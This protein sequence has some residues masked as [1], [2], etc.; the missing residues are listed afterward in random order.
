MSQRVLLPN[1]QP[2][3]VLGPLIDVDG[4]SSKDEDLRPWIENMKSWMRQR[5]AAT[6]VMVARSVS[7]DDSQTGYVSSL[8]LRSSARDEP[9]SAIEAQDSPWMSRSV[10]Q[11]PPSPPQTIKR[12]PPSADAASSSS[13]LRQGNLPPNPPSNL[14]HARNPSQS[15]A[16]T[17][18]LSAVSSSSAHSRQTSSALA[19]P[20]LLPNHTRG[21]SYNAT[22]RLSQQLT[23]KKSLPDL[24]QS[25]AK[26][27]QERR[28]HGKVDDS[29]T[30][31]LGITSPPLHKFNVSM[32]RSVSRDG[33]LYSPTIARLM[34]TTMTRK[35]SIDALRRPVVDQTERRNSQDLPSADD[36]RNS[37]FRR[38]STLPTSTISKTIPPAL[39][40]F[41]DAIRGVLFALSQLHSALRHYLAFA[42]SERA[43]GMFARVMEPAGAYINNLINTLD[44][45]DSMSRRATPPASAIRG[46]LR[47]TKDSVVVFSKMMA[48]LKLQLPAIRGTDT[49]YARTLLTMIYGSMSEVAASWKAMNP[50]LGRIQPL[51]RAEQP[52]AVRAIMAAGHT[53]TRSGSFGV[54]TPISP[55]PERG[56]SHSPPSVPRAQAAGAGASPLRDDDAIDDSPAPLPKIV[57]ADKNRFRRQGGSFSTQ[58]FERGMLMASPVATKSSHG[59]AHRPSASEQLSTTAMTDIEEQEVI[60]PLKESPP[61]ADD[62]HG[63]PIT[64][65]DISSPTV[66]PIVMTQS[67]QHGPSSSSG[68]ANGFVFGSHAHVAP[69]PRLTT[70]G[71]PSTP[72]PA[73][74][75]DKDLLE[76]VEA[77]TEIA[78]DVWLKLAEDVGITQSRPSHS[79]HPSTSS[80]G[81]T[82]SARPSALQPKHQA[83]LAHE[84]RAAESITS[85]LRETL[86]SL[87]ANQNYADTTLSED[88]ATFIKAVIRVSELVKA[89]TRSHTFDPIVRA[90]LSRLTQVTREC[91]ILMQ[92]SSLGRA[93]LSDEVKNG[94][95]PARSGKQASDDLGA[96]LSASLRGLQLPSRQHAL[97]RGRV[98]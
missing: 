19:I 64:P 26:I 38:L 2:R 66:Q 76:V 94:A 98:E 43:A 57:S 23:V 42:V 4:K 85:K 78:F 7:D 62:T 73:T 31:G 79:N 90:A 87:R 45:F 37:Y 53:M 12:V 13:P 3:E 21:S 5:D 74:V 17:P 67:S 97:R 20:P 52:A 59:S 18:P 51:L 9:G 96:P 68:S 24:R 22:Q 88:A 81:S 50:L 65:P 80:A 40:E 39:L 16:S 14:K 75:Y 34:S 27:I 33:S 91:A 49:R 63:V 61:S 71:R 55:I 32:T 15:S 92:V 35:G 89:I 10:S 86:L 25:H 84:L 83:E 44:R 29:R 56:E 47:A 6:Q 70:D 30:M 60:A 54:R 77:A 36:S 82:D 8:V 58:D 93:S 41:I 48:V 72:T 11:L 69:P 1:A 46:V 28:N 95:R